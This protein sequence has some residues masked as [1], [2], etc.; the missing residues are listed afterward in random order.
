MNKASKVLEDLVASQPELLVG[1]HRLSCN[2]P[3]VGKEI[4]LESS[5]AHP[6]LH[7]PA[8]LVS[9]SDQPLV[10]ESVDLVSPPVVH[11]VPKESGDHTAHLL[12]VSSDSHESK[13]DP[14]V[15]VVQE[16]PSSIPAKHEGNHMIPPPS[17]Y[18]VS[19][20]WSHLTTY[21]LPS[22]VPFQ[23]TV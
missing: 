7:E 15:L 6:A 2:P 3:P 21:H 4:D 14:F 5:L 16:S 12:L 11:S 22:Y 19:F 9:I 20:N 10:G 8:S 17:S 23:I 13:N 1:Y 18:V